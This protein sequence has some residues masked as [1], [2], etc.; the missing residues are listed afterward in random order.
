MDDEKDVRN[1]AQAML[2]RLGYEVE[3]VADGAQAVQTYREALEKGRPFD[4]VILDL[5]IPGGMGGKETLEEFRQM[6]PHVRALVSSGYSTDPIMSDLER[7]GFQGVIPKPYRL[8][9]LG[10]A[11]Q[12]CP[13]R[14]GGQEPQTLVI[15]I[16]PR[17]QGKP[18]RAGEFPRTRG[19]GYGSLTRMGGPDVSRKEGNS[20]VSVST[21]LG[22]VASLFG[23][24][25]ALVYS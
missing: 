19:R 12:V 25:P 11:V 24:V 16:D 20:V 22:A 3:T 15:G 8:E 1:L 10:R 14:A 23:P 4:A 9:D 5:T 6:D 7:Y 17:R 13:F 2:Q 21:S 18:L